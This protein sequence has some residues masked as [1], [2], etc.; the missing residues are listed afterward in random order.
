[1]LSNGMTLGSISFSLIVFFFFLR[2]VIC[3]LCLGFIGFVVFAFCLVFLRKDLKMIRKKL[4]QVGPAGMLPQ[5]LD[6]HWLKLP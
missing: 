1:M 2:G 4:Q 6:K 3:I 5:C